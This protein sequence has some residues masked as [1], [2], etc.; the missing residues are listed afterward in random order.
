VRVH[1]K[2]KLRV[3]ANVRSNDGRRTVLR[4]LVAR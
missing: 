3:V 1:G 4:R 2:G